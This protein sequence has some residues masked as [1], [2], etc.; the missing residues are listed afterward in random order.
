[1]RCWMW[2]VVCW[3]GWSWWSGVAWWNA[4]V[5]VLL[6]SCCVVDSRLCVVGC[7]SVI[8]GPWSVEMW[9]KIFD[10]FEKKKRYL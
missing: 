7:A 1:M 6:I 8:V 3:C 10:G 4:V 9:G 2:Y 5:V